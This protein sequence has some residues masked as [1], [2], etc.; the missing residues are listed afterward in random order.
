MLITSSTVLNLHQTQ[1]IYPQWVPD[2]MFHE[3][4]WSEIDSFEMEILYLGWNE[5][6]FSFFPKLQPKMQNSYFPFQ[7]SMLIMYSN[8]TDD[9]SNYFYCNS[10]NGLQKLE[11][12]SIPGT[13]TYY[14]I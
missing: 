1:L 3:K 14:L 12:Y 11:L 2:R 4:A 10:T 7:F 5:R 6:M 9:L 8:V 13:S